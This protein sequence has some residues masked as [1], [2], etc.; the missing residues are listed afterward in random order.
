MNKPQVRNN[1]LTEQLSALLNKKPKLDNKK[2]KKPKATAYHNKE[3]DLQS[4]KSDGVDHINICASAETVL[5]K[6]LCHDTPH[7]YK[8]SILGTFNTVRGFWYYIQSV[9]HDDRYRR[10]SGKPLRLAHNNTETIRVTNF[11]AILMDACWQR[12]K[13]A[14]AIFK[15]MKDSELPFDCYYIHHESKLR[16]RPVY[17][18][19]VTSGT[20]EI[21]KAIK[22]N[23]E[24]DF[25]YLMEDK[26]IDLYEPITPEYLK[27]EESE[28]NI[29]E[30][31][32]GYGPG[33]N[34]QVEYE[35]AEGEEEV[36][37]FNKI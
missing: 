17:H 11:R 21:R 18:S 36:D 10:L 4:W 15:L 31:V 34:D 28:V 30:P 7:R 1:Q 23:R 20:E 19:W 14:G 25:T 9:N 6:F 37:N 8:H 33:I 26:E 22:E 13:Q 5:G 35:L 29:N 32:E 27:S 2:F 24:P 16:V 3:I 12:I